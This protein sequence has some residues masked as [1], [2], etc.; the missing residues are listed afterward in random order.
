VL[1]LEI[2]QVVKEYGADLLGFVFADSRRRITL[3]KAQSIAQEVK[4][5]GKVGVFV[6]AP[7][8]EVQ[9]IVRSCKLDMVQL[10]GDESPEYCQ[11]L[12]LPVIK[13]VRVGGALQIENI[14]AFNVD[15]LL[16]DTYTPG[17]Y[18]GTGVAFD[19]ASAQDMCR[20]LQTKVLIAG[21]LMPHNVA[22]AI[23][24]LNPEGVDVSGGVETNGEKDV[25]KIRR[26]I[27]AAR[28]VQGGEN[29]A[30]EDSGSQVL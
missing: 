7:L 8:H 22:E 5:V 18:G 15:S 9:D 13:A 1:S 25:E 24:I 30:Q 20:R 2:A 10:H 26:F 12:R 14:K 23:R 16:L 17:R 21:G 27:I 29:H 4:G 19:W 3:E 28:S 11:A 6:N